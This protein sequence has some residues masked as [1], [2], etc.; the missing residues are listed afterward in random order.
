MEPSRQTRLGS[1][2]GAHFTKPSSSVKTWNDCHRYVWGAKISPGFDMSIME[3]P[4]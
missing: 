4:G 1:V 3:V 2:V